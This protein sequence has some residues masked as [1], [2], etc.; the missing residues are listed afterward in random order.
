LFFDG[1]DDWGDESA[2][3]HAVA[4]AVGVAETFVENRV[5]QEVYSAFVAHFSQ[6]WGFA[7]REVLA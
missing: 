2:D 4:F 7:L 5:V 1:A 3:A 6:F